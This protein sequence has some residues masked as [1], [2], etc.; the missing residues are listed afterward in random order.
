MSGQTG[1]SQNSF[2][3]DALTTLKDAGAVTSTAAAQVGG[4]DRVLDFGNTTSGPAVEQV[5]YTKGDLVIDVS[6]F[7]FGNSDE[8]A[9]IV[10]QLSDDASGNGAGFDG[11]DTVVNKAAVP[12]GL[13]GGLAGSTADNESATGRVTIKVDNEHKGTLFRFARLFT[14]VG[15]TTPSINYTAEFSRI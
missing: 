7:D 11:G 4:S 1:R 9:L 12:M 3:P 5:A 2:T 15:G 10:F 13:A 8:T 6:A 14:I